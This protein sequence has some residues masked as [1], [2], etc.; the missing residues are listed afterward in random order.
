MP[1]DISNILTHEY[2]LGEIASITR[3]KSGVSNENYKVVVD[4]GQYV[5][6]VCHFE[7][8]NQIKTMI[9]F[10]EY[11]ETTGYPAPRLVRTK[12]GAAY[13]GPET[14]PVVVTTLVPGQ[15]ATDTDINE[16]KLASLGAS[17]ANFHKINWS[18]VLSPKTTNTTYIL[19]VYT[20]FVDADIMPSD[21]VRQF[22]HILAEDYAYFSA[23]ET[24]VLFDSLPQGLIHNDVI[25]GNVLFDDDVVTSFVDL[26]EVGRGIMLLDIAR[27]LNSWC[28]V[29]NQPAELRFAAF[30]RSYE[31]NRPFTTDEIAM[32]TKAM[33][34]IG[35]RN[36][37]YGLK[38]LAQRRIECISNI[39]S[40]ENLKFVRG[41]YGRLEN[42]VQA[43]LTR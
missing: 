26:E 11:A 12:T 4:N 30:L 1:T 27:V 17:L 10:L 7:P 35:F 14:E 28:F 15:A 22:M 29:N 9:P 23:A 39:R 41:N 36:S 8:Q 13:F 43:V 19:N 31:E 37:V 16:N 5:V 21:E 32:I 18:P 38:M 24:Q 20:Q 6:R 34:F 2:Q 40:Y 3:L 25:P 42:L 33:H